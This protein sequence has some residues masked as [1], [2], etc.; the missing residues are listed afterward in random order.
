MRYFWGI[1]VLALM[2]GIDYIHFILIDFSEK[3]EVINILDLSRD[4]IN[5]HRK[6]ITNY[7]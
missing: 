3:S 2:R 5:N 7:Q 6:A 1:K 4:Q